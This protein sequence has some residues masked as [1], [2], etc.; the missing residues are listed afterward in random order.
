MRLLP[1][2][3]FLLAGP[4]SAG[5]VPVV[6]SPVPL[7]PTDPSRRT[8]GLLEY[9]G[10]LQLTSQDPRFGGISS[11][12]L[13]PGGER[14]VAITDEGS[15]LSARL[16]LRDGSLVGLGDVELGPLL[17]PD[18]QAFEGKDTRDAESLALLADGSFVVGFERQHRLLRYPGKSGRPD[19]VPTPVVAPPGLEQA[20]FNGGVEALVPLRG[21]SLLALTEEWKDGD[22]V[23]G[24]VGGP[25]AWARIGYR[26]DG[27]LRPSDAAL[28]PSGDV[29][30]L[31]RGYD[32]RRGIVEVQL[33]EIA[34]DALR[35]G[36]RLL[37]RVVALVQPPLTLDNY[38]GLAVAR[39]GRE[40]RVLIVSDDNFNAA[41]GQRNLLLLFA[42]RP[43]KGPQLSPR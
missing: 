40:T 43:G 16:V 34:R 4:A 30:V 19:G 24:W 29:L 35:P 1:L 3:A 36:S 31:E 10:G 2:C 38:E 27:P 28:L 12:R 22:A 25:T 39:A 5:G 6:S 21:G 37:G 18:G 41:A 13:L 15:W 42:L 17:G 32:A 8:V 23:V 20:P 9:R 14:V 33:R 26:L 7:D 11:I